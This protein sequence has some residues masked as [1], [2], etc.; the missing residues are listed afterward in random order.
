MVTR[1]ELQWWSVARLISLSDQCDTKQN[2]DFCMLGE[3]KQ[4]KD[5]FKNEKKKKS[6]LTSTEWGRERHHVVFF[7]ILLQ[8]L[9][10]GGTSIRLQL[11]WASVKMRPTTTTGVQHRHPLGR[12]RRQHLSLRCQLPLQA[13]H[14]R[15]LLHH[16]QVDWD[17]GVWRSQPSGPWRAS[18]CRS[19]L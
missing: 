9:V 13:Q 15:R 8:P 4:V 1:D 5:G 19:V 16:P 12:F 11:Q 17:A 7:L 10:G 3:E 2:R 18:R 6:A 14:R